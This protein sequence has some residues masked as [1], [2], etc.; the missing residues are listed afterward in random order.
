MRIDIILTVMDI[1]KDFFPE[2]LYKYCL[3]GIFCHLV[4]TFYN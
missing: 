1:F 2:V 3:F 4:D